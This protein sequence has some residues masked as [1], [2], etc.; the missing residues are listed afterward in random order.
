MIRAELQKCMNGIDRYDA[1]L[2]DLIFLDF[3]NNKI[4][5]IRAV[6]YDALL[7]TAIAFI[8]QVHLLWRGVYQ[9]TRCKSDILILLTE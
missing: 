9:N 4:R 2:Y 3:K 8:N 5:Y 1:D 7:Q 6:P